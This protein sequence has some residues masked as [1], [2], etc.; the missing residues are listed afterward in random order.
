V[1]SLAMP[2]EE[3]PAPFNWVLLLF[4]LLFLLG[5]LIGTIACITQGMHDHRRHEQGAV[6]QGTVVA[7]ER[8]ERTGAENDSAYWGHATLRY[9]ARPLG[10]FEGGV[11]LHSSAAVGD[12]VRVHFDAD[13]PQYFDVEELESRSIDA[14]A[15]IFTVL[16]GIVGVWMVL[17]AGVHIG[18]LALGTTLLA[19]VLIATLAQSKGRVPA[20]RV[21]IGDPLSLH[22]LGAAPSGTALDATQDDGSVTMICTSMGQMS[23]GL[24][25]LITLSG[26]A[27]ATK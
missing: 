7:V 4:G 22:A 24:A 17:A 27:S 8:Y 1:D 20:K 11:H 21:S 13:A 9:E 26:R 18:Y 3:S 15:V 25:S 14:V 5:G 2:N 10:T 23:P 16:L 19:I 12:I 6:A